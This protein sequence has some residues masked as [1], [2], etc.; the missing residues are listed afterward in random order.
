MAGLR[1]ASGDN[2]LVNATVVDIHVSRMMS[3]DRGWLVLLN[4]RLDHLNAVK[5]GNSIQSI[6]WKFAERYR[7][8]SK[9]F[10]SRVRRSSACHE[11]RS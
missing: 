2:R 9:E 4:K 3:E 8:N 7:F 1:T 11:F 10:A 5:Q 6:V